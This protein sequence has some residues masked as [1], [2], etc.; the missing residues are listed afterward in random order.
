M[1]IAGTNGKGSTSVALETLLLEMGLRTGTTLSPHIE[2]FNERIRIDGE[3][4]TD[5][6]ICELFSRVE[7]A[8]QGRQGKSPI[9][10]TYFEFAAL[11]A[12]LAFRDAGVQVAV[13]EVGLGGRLDAFNIVDADVAIITSIGLDHQ[14]YLGSDLEQIGREKAGVLRKGQRVVLGSVTESVV[15]AAA[16]LGC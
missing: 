13:L 1:I 16:R 15:D 5:P 12:L 7:A 6:A 14:E 8:R 4:L 3:A 9:E 10:L 11:A 2:V